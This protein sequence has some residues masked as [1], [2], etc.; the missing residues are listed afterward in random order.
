M[1][2]SFAASV[3]R[4]ANQSGETRVHGVGMSQRYVQLTSEY[5]KSEDLWKSLSSA[6]VNPSPTT[7]GSLI[8]F[9]SPVSSL[10]LAD[11]DGQFLQI[12]NAKDSGD[13][14][15]VNFSDHG[16][17]NKATSALLVARDRGPEFALSFRS[18]FLDEWKETIDEKLGDKAE[19]DGN[20]TLTWTMFP[21]G[22]QYLE[23]GRRYLKI[24]QNLKIVLSAWPDYKARISYHVHLFLDSGGMLRGKVARASGWV[25][26]GIKAQAIA[27][28]LKPSL[29]DGMDALQA[30]IDTNLA[31]VPIVFRDLYLL[32]GNQ[33]AFAVTPGTGVVTGST[34][35]DVT[36]MLEAF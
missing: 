28:Q 18:L 9:M 8:L 34:L 30:A 29:E 6:R 2:L 27:D 20:P 11:Y 32:P 36:I 19:R 7:A 3:Y 14:L 35:E 33:S 12:T 13:D 10:N 24:H 4:N 26:A 23:P 17:N 15:D 25:E 21:R 22:I 5:L 1:S 31:A 16:F